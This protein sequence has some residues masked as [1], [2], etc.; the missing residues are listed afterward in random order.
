MKK[1]K[2]IFL[3]GGHPWP[4]QCKRTV[5]KLS[6]NF[7]EGYLRN[8]SVGGT[9]VLRMIY[10]AVRD[11]EWL[12]IKPE[13]KGELMLLTENFSEAVSNYRWTGN[14]D[15]KIIRSDETFSLEPCSL[16]FIEGWLKHS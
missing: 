15:E 2:D 7:E 14:S 8:I 10:F 11:K 9:E 3:H 16:N 1:D 12:T 5:G 6:L 13:I 4:N